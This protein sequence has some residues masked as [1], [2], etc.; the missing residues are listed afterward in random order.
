LCHHTDT[1]QSLASDAP[2]PTGGTSSGSAPVTTLSQDGDTLSSQGGDTVT[3]SQEGSGS[4]TDVAPK[5]SPS[6][7]A[8]THLTFNPGSNKVMLTIQIPLIR[9]IIQDS[10]EDL[11]ATLLFENAFPDP[12]LTILFLRKTLIGAA[13]SRLPDTVNV[14]NRLLLDDE[15]RDKLSRLVSDLT[16]KTLKNM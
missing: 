6:W 12:N 1:F 11:R 8:D 10:F 7:P 15:Y 5:W 4:R 9:T 16:L 3:S 2:A 14:Y 13:R